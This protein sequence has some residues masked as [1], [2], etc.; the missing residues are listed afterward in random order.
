MSIWHSCQGEKHLRSLQLDPWRV[1]EAQHVLSARDL[2]D[3]SEEHDL[4]ESMLEDSKP[5][6]D[7]EKGYLIF[8]PFRYPP[9][10]YGSRF[11]SVLEPS[12]WYGSLELETAFAETAHYR[13][14]F[15]NDSAAD[16][17]YIELILSAFRTRIKTD[18]GIDLSAAPFDTYREQLSSKDSWR[19]SQST[20]TDMRDAG[21][22]AFVFYSARHNEQ[23]KNV[24]SFTPSVFC[25]KDNQYIHNLQ[26]WQCIANREAVE[27][28]RSGFPCEKRYRMTQVPINAHS[29]EQMVN[30]T[31]ENDGY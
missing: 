16:L 22:T 6:V 4:L 31:E 18:K 11:G 3:N 24:A 12:L 26:N 19:H 1:V 21:V 20:G 23:A 28:V 29:N 27:F 10:K 15:L 25:S 9:L 5:P 30:L 7:K 17:G 13:R 14:L 8:T 2:V